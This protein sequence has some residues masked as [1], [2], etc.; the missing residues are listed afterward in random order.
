MMNS[1]Q[2]LAI[3]QIQRVAKQSDALEVINVISSEKSDSFVIVD[4][5]LY[6][7]DL[8]GADG[9]FPIKE[10]ERVRVLIGPDYPYAP[11]SVA[12]SHTRFAGYPHVNWKRWLC[13]Y[14][15][16]QTEWSPRNGMFGFLERL[17]LWLRRAALGELDETGGPIHPPVTYSSKGP[18][19]IPRSDTP[20]VDGEPWLGFANLKQ[21]SP[22]RIDLVGWA[23]DEE[24]AETAGVAILLDAPMPLE[25]PSKLN[26]LIECI[27]DRG[28]SVESVFE[29]LRKAAESNSSDTPLFVV[30]GTPMRGTKGKEL[31]QHLTGWRVDTLLNKIASLDGDLLQDRRVANANDLSDWSA[32]IDEHRGR[33]M[34]LFADWSKEA[35][36]T[37]CRVREDRP[38]IVTRRDNGKPVSWFSGRNLELWGCGAL[39]GYIAEWLVRAGAAKIIL[40]DEGVVTPG[41]LVRQPF[42]DEDIGTFK[43]EALAARLRKI[44]PSCQIETST[45][46]VIECPLGNPGECTDC[47]L[48]IDATASNIVLSKLES[49]WRSSAGIRKRIASVAIDREA[50]RLLVGIAK[51]EHSGGPLDILRKMKLKAC[52]DGTLKRYLDAF[53]PEN[54]PVPFQPEPG[55]SDATFIGSAADAAS[56][57][58]LAVNF[59]GRALSEDLCESTGFGAY[60]SDA[61]A[62]TIA[63]PFV[64]FEFSPD[65]C[66]QDPES[67]FE[68]RIAA[69]AWR[70]IKSWKA[71]SARRRGA[72]VETGG[73][74]FGELD[75]LLKVV[76]VT[77]VSGAPSDSIHSAEEFVCGINGT[78]QLNDSITDQSR[79]SVQFVGSWHTHPVSPAIPSGKDLAAMDRLLVQSPVPSERQ[80]LL[81]IGHASTS[82]ETGAFIFQRKEFES[83]RRSGQL[84]R[85]IAISESPSL[86]PDLLPSIGLSLSGGG[87][88]AMAFHLG[89][90]RALNDRG[91]LD[92]VQVLSTVSGGS[93][94]G[95]MFAFSNT[96]FEEFELDVRAALRRGFAK[97]LV[98]RTLL[99]LR[100][101][102]ILGTWIFSGV[103]ANM[104]FATRF[105]LGRANSLVPKD[106]RAG[107]TVAQSLQPPFRRWVNRTNALEQT[108]ADLLFG[109]TKVAQVARDGL[110][111]VINA[112]E[113][114]TGTAF[115]FGNRESGCWRFGTIENN[116]V[117]VARA[118][119]ASAAY[120]A[121]LPAIDTVLQYSHGS[122]DGESKRTILTDGGVYE[123]LGI[124]CMIPGRD[125]AFSTNVF[126][127]DYIV[128]CDAGPGQFSDTVMPYGWGTRMMRSIETT[129]RQVQHGLQKQIHMCRENRELKG[130][131][132]SYLGQQDAR[133]P[134]RPPELVTRDQ[135]THYPT[136]FFAMS[137][138]DIELLSQRGEQLTRLLIDH[139]CPEL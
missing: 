36:I 67:G 90:L 25:F 35:D 33:L 133:L 83:L 85:Q 59:I 95:A 78:T 49:V 11:P 42:H 107:G 76:W 119:A 27:A 111:V 80:L 130:F 44:S 74:L 123:N 3:D 110:D 131:V 69:S 101:F 132:Y 64:K 66:V 5:S 87:S 122:S 2:K 45:K 18:L 20:N 139:Y 70:S 109:E 22:D 62:E 38:E 32:S 68:T 93:V 105:I 102:Q 104:T 115:R 91:V 137:N 39:G 92:R 98:R 12:S 75:E 65:H 121:L 48:I 89:C 120:P 73:L 55:C 116:D 37:W 81:I 58:S 51:P 106:S 1:E 23:R 88:R 100:L 117:S 108:F 96:P 8:V 79:R 61:C 57:S 15:A 16:P 72:D 29:L 77:E 71:D 40:R 54:P 126:S 135:V 134:I 127:P 82:M 63:P 47:D 53:F 136:D 24:L 7:G 46:D 118:V 128:C 43:A 138:T 21:I 19:L 86:R 99:S 6:C 56:L 124:S 60:M 84:S 26:E 125:K 52:K 129:F 113:L 14:L 114:R 97:G 94:I 10:R 28:V 30:V 17:E 50:E 41:L 34:E 31:K 4:L 103:P 13:L 112:T 9:G